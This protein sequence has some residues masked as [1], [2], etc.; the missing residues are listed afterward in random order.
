MKKIFYILFIFVIIF[1]GNSCFNADSLT[2][3]QTN[4][5]YFKKVCQTN[6]KNS[7]SIKPLIMEW[8]EIKRYKNKSIIRSVFVSGAS[9]ASIMWEVRCVWEMAKE[10]NAK[11]VYK[12]KSAKQAKNRNEKGR[13]YMQ[14]IGFSNSTNIN[15]NTYFQEDKIEDTK[16]IR[17][18]MFDILFDKQKR[19]N[20]NR[21]NNPRDTTPKE[22]E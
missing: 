14:I 22:T 6:I 4:L 9:V 11:Y 7:R 18:A 10:R 12:L 16:P 5:L 1:L 2:N 17:I 3:T 13:V 19:E 20:I 8:K 15:L 21:V